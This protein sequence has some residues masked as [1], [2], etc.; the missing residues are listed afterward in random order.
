MTIKNDLLKKLFFLAAVGY[1]GAK[2][3]AWLGK[4]V[5]N[6]V[7]DNFIKRIMVDPYSE[8]LW[9]FAS[10]SQRTGLQDIVEINLRTQEGKTIKRPLGSPKKFPDFSGIMFNFA[11]LHR[12]PTDEG[13]PI[14]TRV[15]IGPRAQKPLEIKLPIMIS[16]MAY[17]FAL[18][19]K[20]KIGLA[21]GSSLAGTATNT[22]EGPF[23]PAERKAADKLILQYNRG[24]WNKSE[25][26]LKQA[27]MIEIHIGQGAAGG[28]GHY[29]ED[30]EIDWKIRRMMGLGWGEKGVI[31]A[32]FPGMDKPNYLKDLITYLKEV[33]KGVPVGVKL[34]ASKYLEKDMEIAVESGVDVITIDGSEAASKGTAPILQDDFGL[35]SLFAIIRAAKFINKYKLKNKVSLILS[36]GLENPGDFLKA[37][38]LGADALYIGSTALFAMSHT[39]VLKALPWEPPPEIVFYKGKHQKE[40]DVEKGAQSLASFLNACNEEIKE[41]VRALG[42]NSIHE[43]NKDD[44]FALD[45]QTAEVVGIP[46]GYKEINYENAKNAPV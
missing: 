20:A 25:K 21:R 37:I 3:T 35:P 40:F 12:L 41:A 29:I 22:G 44:L 32:K 9:E 42:K 14:D 45:S 46:L 30:K 43:V 7:S 8:N 28:V 24:K 38:A 6:K 19:A 13:K 5:I 36:G 17:A 2:G 33:T 4:K 27:D 39:Q 31:H 26:I 10:A 23:L 16:G 11:Q 18:S 15:I 34:A 1:A